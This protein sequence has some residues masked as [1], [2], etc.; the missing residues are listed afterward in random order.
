MICAAFI[1]MTFVTGEIYRSVTE[2]EFDWASEHTHLEQFALDTLQ[3]VIEKLK[4]VPVYITIDLDVLDPSVFPG[5]GTPEPGGITYRELLQAIAQFQQL[6]Q[7]VAA[8][9]VEL[10]PQYDPSGASTA[11]ACKTIREMLLTL[12]K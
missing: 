6:N 5:T 2:E 3:E 1:V 9:V 11:V 4:D 12:A 10:S 7:I 8:D